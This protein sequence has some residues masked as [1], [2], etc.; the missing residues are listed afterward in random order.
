[1]SATL[2]RTEMGLQMHEGA[3]EL[4]ADR[5]HLCHD[6]H[7]D[8]ELEPCGRVECAWCGADLG[9]AGGLEAGEVSHGMCKRCAD[10]FCKDLPS[11][12]SQSKPA[13]DRGAQ[14]AAASGARPGGLISARPHPQGGWT[15]AYPFGG[16]ARRYWGWFARESEAQAAA[17]LENGRAA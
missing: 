1:M 10:D 2:V 9:P 14:P 8:D 15:L 5:E 11:P 4:A 12:T 7:L 6:L 17:D 3:A 13:G 16:S